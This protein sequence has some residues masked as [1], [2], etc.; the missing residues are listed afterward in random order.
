MRAK[1]RTIITYI[2][3][4]HTRSLAELDAFIIS[5]SRALCILMSLLTFTHFAFVSGR[6]V[7]LYSR[8]IHDSTLPFAIQTMSAKLLLN[9]VE[10][11]AR[12]NALETNEGRS[13]L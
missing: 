6:V 7:A 12:K 1:L 10:G 4:L 13:L 5:I 2:Y 8:N 3:I 11:I 9:L